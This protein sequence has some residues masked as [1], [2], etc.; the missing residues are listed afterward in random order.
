MTTRPIVSGYS[1][2]NDEWVSS[3]LNIGFN[4]IKSGYVSYTRTYVTHHYSADSNSEEGRSHLGV[5]VPQSP[6]IMC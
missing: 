3:L 4:Y 5:R 6:E 2:V 1:S